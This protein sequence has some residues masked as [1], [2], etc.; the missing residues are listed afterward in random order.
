MGGVVGPE[1]GKWQSARRK[2]S[3]A[4]ETRAWQKSP[5]IT[6]GLAQV[7]ATSGAGL[8]VLY[9]MYHYILFLFRLFYFCQVTTPFCFL[10]W[11]PKQSIWD[12]KNAMSAWK[13]PRQA[14]RS[15]A[16]L[17]TSRLTAKILPSDTILPEASQR[18]RAASAHQICPPVTV[19]TGHSLG[20]LLV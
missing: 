1:Q 7:D 11:P 6:S 8:T 18:S 4:W 12:N 19:Q 13:P 20:S 10:N 9:P 2:V 17:F 5:F 3:T 14:A 15:V 16:Q